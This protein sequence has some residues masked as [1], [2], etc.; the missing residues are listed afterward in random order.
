[1]RPKR[2]V[3]SNYR[4]NLTAGADC[5]RQSEAPTGARR[6]LGVRYTDKVEEPKG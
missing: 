5:L 3:A 6:R 1:M 4:L 2:V